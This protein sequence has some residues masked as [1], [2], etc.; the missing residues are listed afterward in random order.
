M[1]ILYAMCGLPFAGKSTAARA[2]QS[3]TNARLVQ[4]DAIN[5]ERGLGLDGSAI[6]EHEWSRTYAE[7]Y[8]RVAH[9]LEDGEVVIFDHGNFTRSERDAVREIARRAGSEVRFI[10]VPANV[11]EA[12][13]RWLAN[14]QTHE[15]YDVRDED[16]DLALRMF[17]PPDAEPDVLPLAALRRELSF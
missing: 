8:R 11:D 10:Y 14:R 15:R 16:F 3:R 5:A 13:R 12:R 1:P 7:A 17:E 9:H 4:L 2:L 6:P